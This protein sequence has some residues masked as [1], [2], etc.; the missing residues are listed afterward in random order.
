[1]LGP[2][3][4]PSPVPIPPGSRPGASPGLEATIPIIDIRS[5]AHSVTVA[6][7]EDGIRANVLS[8]FTKPYN[9]KE[10]PNLLLYNEEG[11]RLFEQITYQPDYYL[12]RLEI[13]ILSRH[14]HQIANS[15]PD[16]AILLE[17]GA[18]A[19]RKTA[20][21]LDAL[22]AQGKDVTYFALDLDKPELLRTLAEVKG[23]YT[24]V[25]LAGLWGTYDDGCT[26]LKQVK[27]RPRII[28]WLGSSVGNMS[29][30]EAG[31]FIRTFG[32]ILA[33]RDRFIV[34]IDSKNH[35]LNDIRA[36][37][38]D[39]AGVTRRF[40]L[41]ALGNINDLFNADVVDVSSFDYNPYYN[42]VQGRN[43]AY[44]RCLK[45]TQVRIPSE[46]PIL[47]HEGEYIRFAFSHKY[48]RVERQ[49][50]WT[51]AGAY[52]V[53]EWMSQDGDYALTMLS[54]SS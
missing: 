46:T 45:D 14:A 17:L 7:L 24:H 16:G 37:Y 22:E 20:L 32:D 23:R 26:W 42:E 29:R 6:A 33:P 10:L 18:G 36:A 15:V 12:T 35:K 3:P 40:A 19:L 53:Q 34:A 51:A 5:T 2:V 43:E 11:L 50:L 13:D 31:Q 38:D 41:N 44:F 52:P 54:W 8:G 28:L 25:S 48:D 9:E 27:D 47:V 49:V 30:K 39:R 21:I 1:M 4:S